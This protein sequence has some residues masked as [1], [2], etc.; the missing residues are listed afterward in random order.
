[1]VFVE[2]FFDYSSPWTYLAF[3]QLHDIFTTLKEK[4]KVEVQVSYKP[5]LVGG[6]FNQVNPSVYEARK[7]MAKAPTKALYG[8]KDLKEWAETYGLKVRGPYEPNPED[9]VQPFPVNSVKSLRGALFFLQDNGAEEDQLHTFREYSMKVFQSYWSHSKDIS[10]L[11]VLK[12]IVSSLKVTKEGR[13][14]SPVDLEAFVRFIELQETKDRIKSYT[15]ECMDRG[16][17]GSPTIFVNKKHMYF[18]ND[19]LVLMERRILSEAERTGSHSPV[20][21]GRPTFLPSSL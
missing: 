4:Q 12:E 5:I 17:F 15:Q 16:G 21:L 10:N 13:H 8:V 1:M 11:D 18:G 14:A 3:S 7:T 19:R 20:L 2:V 6:I 9:R